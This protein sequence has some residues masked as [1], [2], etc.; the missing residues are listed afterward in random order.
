MK[1][2][3]GFAILFLTIVM[4]LFGHSAFGAVGEGGA[5]VEADKAAEQLAITAPVTGTACKVG[6]LSFATANDT[7]LSTTSIVFVDVPDMSVDFKVAGKN[8]CLIVA[9]SAYVF[10]ASGRLMFVRA[11][12]DGV[13]IGEPSPE[14]QFDGDSDENADGRWARS[15]AFN[16]AFVNVGPGV[17]NLKIQWRSFDGGQIFVNRRSVFVHHP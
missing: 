8:R 4:M 14:V 13:T 10:A 2:S 7:G 16:F 6:K 9:F 5:P 1:C 17:H 3:T 11:L 15:H 12:L